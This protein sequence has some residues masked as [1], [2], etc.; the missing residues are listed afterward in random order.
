VKGQTLNEDWEGEELLD[1]KD[2]QLPDALRE[3]AKK[4]RNPGRYVIETGEG[5][6]VLYA[7]DGEL[8][9]LYFLK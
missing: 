9:D 3:Y 5:E 8:L 2:S 6:Y 4:F 1:I 7:E